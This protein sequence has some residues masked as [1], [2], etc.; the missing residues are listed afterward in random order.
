MNVHGCKIALY[1]NHVWRFKKELLG[2]LFR[3]ELGYRKNKYDI[4]IKIIQIIFT[5]HFQEHGLFSSIYIEEFSLLPQI[6]LS[7]KR[8]ASLRYVSISMISKARDY[9]FKILF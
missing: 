1:F 4:K 8:D 2:L 6:A 3:N 9:F 5:H 7:S